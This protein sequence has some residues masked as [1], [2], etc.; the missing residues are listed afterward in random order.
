MVGDIGPPVSG[1]RKRANLAF[2]D[3]VFNSWIIWYIYIFNFS[4]THH[5]VFHSG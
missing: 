3:D 1:V 5:T 2:K 4:R